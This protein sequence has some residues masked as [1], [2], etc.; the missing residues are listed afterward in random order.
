MADTDAD[1]DL[2][3]FHRVRILHPFSR[4]AVTH[5]SRN[6]DKESPKPIVPLGNVAKPTYTTKYIEVGNKRRERRNTM[7][8]AYAR[9][10]Y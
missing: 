9:F 8:E 5:L 4:R 6:S 7:R 1:D 3:L 10:Y 2:R